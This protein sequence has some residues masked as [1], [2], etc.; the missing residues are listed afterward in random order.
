MMPGMRGMNQKQMMKRMGIKNEDIG[1]VTKV[2]IKTEDKDYVLDHPEVQLMRAQGQ[3]IFNIV[4][5]YEIVEP[6]A[7][8]EEG[9]GEEGGLRIPQEDIEL[10]ARQTNVS[11]EEALA[12]LEECDGEP[13][14]AIILLMSRG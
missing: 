9:G 14:E 8:G 6:G 1:R 5:D 3:T 13:A 11:D 2:I 7:G 12:A 10:V 4:G